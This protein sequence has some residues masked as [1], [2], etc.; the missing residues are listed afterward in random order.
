MDLDMAKMEEKWRVFWE[1]H[2][3]YAFNPDARGKIFKMT[4]RNYK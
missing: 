2:S 4:L 3:T 1:E